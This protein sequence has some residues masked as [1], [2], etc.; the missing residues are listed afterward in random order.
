MSDP[1]KIARLVVQGVAGA[2]E[3]RAGRRVDDLKA[4][5]FE[6][7]AIDF[8]LVAPLGG[9]ETAEQ[10]FRPFTSPA[11]AVKTRSGRPSCAGRRLTRA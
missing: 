5:L 9:A 2:F 4:V 6:P 1:V 10:N 11:L 3:K 8:L 7:F